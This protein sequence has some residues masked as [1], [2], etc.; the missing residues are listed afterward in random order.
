MAQGSAYELGAILVAYLH[1]DMIG[2]VA[3]AVR[4]IA[5]TPFTLIA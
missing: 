4:V 5:C 1:H 3:R 2:R